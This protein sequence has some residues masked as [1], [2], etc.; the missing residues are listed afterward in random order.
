KAANSEVG[1]QRSAGIARK[2]CAGASGSRMWRRAS[3]RQLACTPAAFLQRHFTH[4]FFLLNL[5]AS[6]SLTTYPATNRCGLHRATPFFVPKALLFRR[7][8]TLCATIA[9][10]EFQILVIKLW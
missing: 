10:G 5:L 8:D 4:V 1:S 9:A 3:Y 6:H 2:R 7:P